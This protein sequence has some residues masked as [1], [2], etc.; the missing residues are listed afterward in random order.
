MILL[1]TP[2]FDKTDQNPGYIKSYVPGV[3]ENGGQYTHG[4]IWVICAYA[5][6]RW[7]HG[8]KALHM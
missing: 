3:R 4:V 5:L 7:E 1:F 8:S 2:P 6:L